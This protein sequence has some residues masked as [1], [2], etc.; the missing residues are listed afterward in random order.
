MTAKKF[1]L[2]YGNP[3]AFFHQARRP[4]VAYGGLE[5]GSIG[6]GPVGVDMR[7]VVAISPALCSDPYMTLTLDVHSGL[8]LHVYL[9]KEEPTETFEES[10]T[11]LLN[12]WRAIR[13]ATPVYRME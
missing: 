5:V 6:T 9:N 8:Q 1:K 7:G 3:I 4:G 10:A 11:R 12:E 2:S 13:E